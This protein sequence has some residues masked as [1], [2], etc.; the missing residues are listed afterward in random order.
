MKKNLIT[1]SLTLLSSN[2]DKTKDS[3]ISLDSI[4]K[5]LD[6]LRSTVESRKILY[7]T[8]GSGEVRILRMDDINVSN[9][10][11]GR[12]MV[13]NS[14]EKKFKFVDV[15]TASN[16]GR[17]ALVVTEDYTVTSDDYYIGVQTSSDQISIAIPDTFVNGKEL[18][19]KDE[20]GT[21]SLIPIRL[22]GTIDNDL[23]GAIISIDNGSLSLINRNGWRIV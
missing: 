6:I 18:I 10:S 23:A 2:S 3:V 21:A 8:P 17:P 19:I 4:K 11:D 7:V 9:L 16:L 14:S 1:E 12:M 13:W 22:V 5:D 15:P 20:S